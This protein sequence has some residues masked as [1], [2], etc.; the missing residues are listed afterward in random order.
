MRGLGEKIEEV[1]VVKKV[2][3]T[4]SPKY[5]SKTS[6]VEERDMKKLTVDALHRIFIAYEMRKINENP[7]KET[8]FKIVKKEN[9]VNLESEK[10]NDD[11]SVFVSKLKRGSAGRYKGKLP[12]KCFNC[13]KIGHY[14]TNC[15][16]KELDS[17]EE[18]NKKQS[19]KK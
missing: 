5:D 15:P 19:R 17:D 18:D 11:E 4:W 14:A 7:N 6:A 16:N 1:T 2:L 8:T 10:V 13:G 12:F 9:E 3:R